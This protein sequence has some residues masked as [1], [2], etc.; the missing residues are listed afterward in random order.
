MDDTKAMRGVERRDDL[1]RAAA[2]GLG[3]ERPASQPIGQGLP[4]QELHHQIID[5]AAVAD[6]ERVQMCG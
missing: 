5:V 4:F 2:S 3:R 6:V 1:Q